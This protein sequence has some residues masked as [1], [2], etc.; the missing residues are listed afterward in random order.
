MSKPIRILLIDDHQVARYG[1]RLMLSAAPDLEVIAEAPNA[2]RGLHML[3]TERYDVVLLDLGLPDRNG[4]D[5]LRL[6]R[7]RHPGVATL[8]V[9]AQ[10]EDS[11][12]VRAL[13]SGAAGFLTKDATPDVLQA[14]VRKAASGGKYVTPSLLQKLA[15][16]LGGDQANAAHER[17][18]DREFEVFKLIASGLSLVDIAATLHLS[19]STITTYRARILE[20]M[21]LK[22]NADLTRYAVDHDLLN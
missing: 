17:L 4:L 2:A 13:R 18:T 9:S 5:V 20:K 14:A 3:D 22:G 10:P 7:E 16:M 8:I 6:I 21:G 19:P 12:A 15:D 1:L 11:Y